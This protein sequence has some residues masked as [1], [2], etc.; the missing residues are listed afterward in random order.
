MNGSAPGQT[1]ARAF[2][3]GARLLLAATIV[4]VLSHAST[5]AHAQSAGDTSQRELRIERSL[6][7][8][9]CTDL[10]L[11]VCDQDICND[12]RAI[13]HQKVGAGESDAAIRQY[14]VQRYGSRVLL[15][16]PTD[17]FGFL[18]WVLPF[19]ALAIGAGLTIAYLRSARV[20]GDEAETMTLALDEATDG[21]GYRARVEREV[22]ELE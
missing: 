20:K 4:A 10:P 11:D 21:A 15:A 19:A 16:P 12:M 5:G 1:E 2:V 9:Q 22:G 6:A 8:P 13:I 14:F 7:C 18:V 17:S 3:R